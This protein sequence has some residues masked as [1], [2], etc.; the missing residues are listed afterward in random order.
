V[1]TVR[2]RDLAW[3]VALIV[4]LS[5][6]WVARGDVAGAGTDPPGE[7]IAVVYIAVGTGFA[8]ALGVGP[9]AGLGGAPVII[10]PTNPPLDTATS[11][12]LIRLDPRAVIIIGGTSAVS[13]LM[14]DTL[15]ALLP[16][17]DVSRIAGTNRYKTNAAFSAATFPIESWV[18]VA[19]SAFTAP[20]PAAESAYVGAYAL[21]E[22]P[23]S[24][25]A[26]YA[27]IFL[28]HGAQVLE[29]KAEVFDADASQG[30]TVSLWRVSDASYP[31]QTLASKSTSALFSAGDEV[32][33]DTTITAGTEIVDNSAYCYFV[34]IVDAD[35]NPFVQSVMVRYRLGSP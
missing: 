2:R 26:L 19:P 5:A 9:G 27:P 31:G 12:E 1:F 15:E 33:S 13:D 4:L 23:T 8:D 14:E 17:A 10:V 21:N 7:G 18:S 25:Y 28:P 22:D 34:K 6:V 20:W 35:G 3:A 24:G 16:N 30:V 32:L 29:L 11:A